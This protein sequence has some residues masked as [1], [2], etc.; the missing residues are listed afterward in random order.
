MCTAADSSLKIWT[1]QP[2]GGINESPVATLF[3]HEEGVSACCWTPDARHLVS[4]SDDQTARLWDVERAAPVATLG[5][6]SRAR[7]GGGDPANQAAALLAQLSSSGGHE[8]TTAANEDSH[9]DFV[10]CCAVNPQGSLIATGSSDESVRLWDARSAHSVAQL[11]AHQEPVTG[12]D[13][14]PDGTLLATSGLDG[15]VRVWDVAA[16]QCLRTFAA[17]PAAPAG[18]ALFTGNG[19]FVLG[20]T[21][22]GRLRLWDVAKSRATRVFGGF[23]NRKF[24]LQPAFVRGDDGR[25]MVVSGSEDHTICM[26]DVNGKTEAPVEVLEGHDAPV[27]A[28][29][30]HPSAPVLA[31]AGD[32][33]L[34]LWR[35]VGKDEQ[36]EAE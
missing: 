6:T 29:D 33:T 9:T 32:R 5:A 34:K 26:W 14:S 13:F 18:S 17:D 31:S 10:L 23:S 2:D 16:R 11:V 25:A 15:L 27:L 20:G 3:G 21:L 28:V 7:L 36:A 24:F 8:T 22:D 12:I 1:V 4:A 30:A 35:R 19:R